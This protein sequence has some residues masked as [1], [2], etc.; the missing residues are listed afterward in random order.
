MLIKILLTLFLSICSGILG[1]MG[2]AEGYDTL[3][4]DVGCSLLSILAFI[5]WFGFKTNYW[6]IYLIVFGLQWLAFTTY[7]DWL[8]KFDNLWFAGFIVG[9]ALLPLFFVDKI[10][11][12]FLIRVIL[13][14]FVWGLLNKLLPSYVFYW[15]HDIAEEFLRYFSVIITYL[16][17]V[18]K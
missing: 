17:G 18:L 13:L 7:W 10:L 14:A 12:F 9:V 2:G 15:R 5:L 3:Y 11:P 4:R 1:R 6:W 8:F 16:L